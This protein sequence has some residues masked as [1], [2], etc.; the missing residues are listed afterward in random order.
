MQTYNYTYKDFHDD[1]GHLEASIKIQFPLFKPDLII[2]FARGGLI[3]AVCLSHRLGIELESVNW[4]R[5]KTARD[6]CYHVGDYINEGKKILIV[7]DIL[8][9]GMSVDTFIEHLQNG[10]VEELN[11]DNIKVAALVRYSDCPV[12]GDHVALTLDREKYDWTH[13][14]WESNTR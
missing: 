11:K 12:E 13:F 3:P 9:T 8:D 7:D 10:Q 2:G 6:E 14:W 1:L 5:N 4:P